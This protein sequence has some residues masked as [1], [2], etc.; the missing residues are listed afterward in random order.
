MI[1]YSEGLL[2]N[3]GRTMLRL[4]LIYLIL[5]F[6]MSAEELD[7]SGRIFRKEYKKLIKPVYGKWK[8]YKYGKCDPQWG[9]CSLED[10]CA[11]FLLNKTLVIKK[12]YL[13]L[14]EDIP[15]LNLGMGYYTTKK[16]EYK[17]SE[18]EITEMTCE[19][20]FEYQRWQDCS[21][22]DSKLQDDLRDFW[23]HGCSGSIVKIFTY[24][25]QYDDIVI[26]I[27]GRAIFLK[28]I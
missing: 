14:V 22:M 13:E 12:K 11:E 24:R 19:K 4:I 5:F 16:C 26:W 18:L 10:S 1:H 23:I 3:I 2:N 25:K 17:F 8:I 20:Q 27:H 21:D 7:N 6:H 15:C 28:R 9:V